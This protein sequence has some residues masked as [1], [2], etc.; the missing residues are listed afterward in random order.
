[1]RQAI[2]TYGPMVV[3]AWGCLPRRLV[4]VGGSVLILLRQLGVQPRVLRLN[5]GG[6]P[7]HPLYLGLDAEPY[8]W[9]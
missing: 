7:G 6:E 3:C 4:H 5:A 1:L 2:E 8:I 9:I